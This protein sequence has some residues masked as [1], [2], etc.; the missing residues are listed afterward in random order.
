M[1][2]INI[3]LLK[4]DDLFYIKSY[5]TNIYCLKVSMKLKLP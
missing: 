1:K 4:N 5:K 3:L 2:T